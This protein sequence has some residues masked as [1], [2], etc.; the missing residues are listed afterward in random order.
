MGERL[1][2]LD[3]VNGEKT[4]CIIRQQRERLLR[5]EGLAERDTQDYATLLVGFTVIC[6]AFCNGRELAIADSTKGDA[7]G[8][9]AL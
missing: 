8:Q 7:N 6:G 3:E 1:F 5:V 9:R 4:K 2:T